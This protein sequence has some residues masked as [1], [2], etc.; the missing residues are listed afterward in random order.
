[1]DIT[2]SKL[3]SSLSWFILMTSDQLGPH[4]QLATCTKSKEKLGWQPKYDLPALN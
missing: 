3:K 2:D 1:M 4:S